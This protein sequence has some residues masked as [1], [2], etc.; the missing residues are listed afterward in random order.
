ME[1]PG[2]A[3]LAQLVE[4]SG[5]QSQVQEFK[6]PL[7]VGPTFLKNADSL[8]KIHTQV[9]LN[10]LGKKTIQPSIFNKLDKLFSI[11]FTV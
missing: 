5:F 11:H 6:P 4:A 7:G 1:L 8:L 10:Y 9:L 2:D 3:W